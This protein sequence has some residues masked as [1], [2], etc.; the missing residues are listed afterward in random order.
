MVM[1]IYDRQ[2]GFDDVF[3]L[4]REPGFIDLPAR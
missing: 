1:R 2:F 3:A 4:L